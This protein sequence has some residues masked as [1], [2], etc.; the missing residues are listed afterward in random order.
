M[1]LRSVFRFAF[2]LVFKIYAE[3][4]VLNFMFR[5]KSMFYDVFLFFLYLLSCSCKCKYDLNGILLC[6]VLTSSE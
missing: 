6:G 2:L 5:D 3:I 1:N 4:I